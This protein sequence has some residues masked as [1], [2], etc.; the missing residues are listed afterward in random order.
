MQK[1]HFDVL[2][3]GA[4]ISGISAATHLKSRCPDRSFAILENRDTIGG[5]WD[6]FRYPGIRSDSDMF[7]LGYRFK[8][9]TGERAI[10]GASDILAYLKETAQEQNIYDH[11]RFGHHVEAASWDSK[12]A[13]WTVSATKNG[14]S[15]TL[16]CNFL[17]MCSG[18]YDYD[19]GYTP[20]FEG[21]ETFQGTIIHP[22]HWPEDL[23]Y[24]GKRVVVIGSGA[25]AVT[26]VPEMAKTAAH[27][28]MLQRSPSYVISRPSRDAF[29]NRLRKLLPAKLAY[30]I[31]RWKYVLLQFLTFKL[32]RSQPAFIKRTLLKRVRKQLG[33]DYDIGTHFTPRYN[34][35]EQRLCLVPDHDLYTAITSGTASVITDHIDRFT[36]AGIKLKSG[37]K[38]DADII[39]TATGLN[40]LFL[41]G[42][43][44]SVDGKLIDFSQT[45]SYRGVMFSG[46]PNLATVF[47][48]INASWT[49]KA[50][51]AAEF[52]CRLLNTMKANGTD[53][54]APEC[55]DPEIIPEPW[56]DFSS[57]FFQRGLPNFPKQGGKHPWKLN[58]SYGQDILMLRHRR[59]DDGTLKFR[60]A[61]ASV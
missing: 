58:Q 46:V 33:P 24:S 30:R 55:D 56:I 59:L 49:L 21:A 6:L 12:A 61:R 9:W 28:T 35:W 23:D 2:I 5:T 51:L 22:Q 40:L 29:A 38:L 53:I 1:D 3:V 15:V 19:K 45:Y 7:T 26:L 10:A 27:V 31:I 48:Y 32:A 37:Q 13:R 36:E 34:P 20:V 4:G 54:A 8:P 47:G 60:K 50:D 41:A 25:T 52:V 14:A 42:M 17:F 16:T 18:Y 43:K 11:I 57:G 44:T 39:V